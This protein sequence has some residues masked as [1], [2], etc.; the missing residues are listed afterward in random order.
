MKNKYIKGIFV[1]RPN[2]FIGEILV[3][4]ELVIAHVPNTGRCKELLIPNET[5]VYLEKSNNPNR[6]TKYS[7]VLVENR[8]ELVSID[9]QLP[10]KIVYEALKDKAISELTTYGIIKKEATIKQSRMDFYLSKDDDKKGC[11]MEVKGVTLVDDNHCALFPDAPTERGS[12]HIQTLIALKEEGYRCVIFFLIQHPLGHFFTPNTQQDPTFSKLVYQAKKA[13][14][15]VLVY[16][17]DVTLDGQIK[18]GGKI[19]FKDED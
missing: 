18:I 7:L 6:K 5:T 12:K 9:S 17:C 3:D 16:T 4:G 19:P 13:G 2:R 10:N 1:N 11:Y 8:G 14:V 15:E